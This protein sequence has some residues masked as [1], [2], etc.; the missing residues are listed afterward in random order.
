MPQHGLAYKYISNAQMEPTNWFLIK[1]TRYLPKHILTEIDPV[2][3]RNSYLAHPENG[4]LAMI[5]DEN[6]SYR[7]LTLNKI[8]EL[9]ESNAS[10]NRIFTT[11]AC[12]LNH[13]QKSPILTTSWILIKLGFNTKM[14]L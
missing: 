9:R 4:L 8:L 12:K 2:L 1:A 7:N 10:N 3:Q 14:Y 6:K 13:M 5:C 11:V